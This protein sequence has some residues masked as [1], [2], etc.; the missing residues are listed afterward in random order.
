MDG[1][2]LVL[3]ISGAVT[4]LVLVSGMYAASTRNQVLGSYSYEYAGNALVALHYAR[5]SD[6][7]WFWLQLE[8]KRESSDPSGDT[9]DYLKANLDLIEKIS[10]S[11]PAGTNLL[12]FS[13]SGSFS[14]CYNLNNNGES[15]S[16]LPDPVCGPG[17]NAYSYTSFIGDEK[18]SFI[19]CY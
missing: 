18:I 1:L 9:E 10:A 6:G 2:I 3:V 8:E 16:P 14:D 15:L 13:S 7:N 12:C 4:M 11:S 17:S 19:L 5:D